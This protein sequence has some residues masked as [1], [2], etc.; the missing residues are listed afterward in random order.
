MRTRSKITKLS[1][2]HAPDG[3]C[4]RPKI[5]SICAESDVSLC[6]PRYI[7]TSRKI[8]DTYTYTPA[9]KLGAPA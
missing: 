3:H 8:R 5:G 2:V 6:S 1:G 7:S 9:P 4:R